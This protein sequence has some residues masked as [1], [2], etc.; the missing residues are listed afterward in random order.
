[1]YLDHEQIKKIISYDALV[2]E[3]RR[4]L[5]EFS[6]G[7][8][9]Q[10]LRTILAVPQ[11]HGRFAVMPAVYGDVMGAKMVS[12]YPGN[13]SH[14]LPTHSSEIH[15]FSAVTGQSLAILHGDLITEMRTAAV[16]SIAAD[17]LSPPHARVLAILGAGTQACAHA[18]AL[19][20]VRSFD[21]VYVWSRNPIA[22]QN[23]AREI[24][25]RAATIAEAVRHADVIVTATSASEPI[26]CGDQIKQNALVIAVGAVGP[27]LRELDNAAMA[28]TLV[29]ESRE[30]ALLESGDVILSGATVYAEL[31]E[32]LAGT[33][34]LPKTDRIVYKSLGIAV[35]DV[36]TA[37]LI[38]KLFSAAF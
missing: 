3:M 30:A 8:V 17:L 16:S 34:S 20:R 19:R 28:G 7:R 21:E 23:L 5:I 13:A 35:E 31:G 6:A 2:P 9:T 11:H 10:P 1:M 14:N 18:T 38:F 12:V 37:N 24:G 26:L 27:S 4:A 15:L 25:G 36:A 22:V 32:L 29:V 33:K